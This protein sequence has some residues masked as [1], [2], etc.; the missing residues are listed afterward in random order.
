VRAA[1]VRRKDTPFREKGRAA[2]LGA[3]VLGFGALARS[4]NLSGFVRTSKGALKKGLG[5]AIRAHAPDPSP[6]DASHFGLQR[7]EAGELAISGVSLPS[8]GAQFGSPL[9]VVN[10]ARLRDNARRFVNAARKGPASC[11]VFYSFKT[12]PVPG[13]I[14][15]LKAEGIGAEVIS[16]YELWLAQRLGFPPERIVYNGPVKSEASLREAIA[17]D[18]LMLNV[19]HR[20]ELPLLVRVARELGRRPRVGVRV[21]LPGGWAGQFG[22]P[23]AK[24]MALRVFEEARDSGALSVVGLHVHRGGM[25]RSL[26]DVESFVEQA[27]AFTD[28]LRERL[29]IELSLLNLGGSL[30]SPS[31]RGLGERELRLN[32]TFSS[33]IVAPEPAEALTI[34]Q[35]LAVVSERVAA[36]YGRIGKVAPRVLLEPGRSLTSDAQMLLTRVQ[37]LKADGD[38]EYAILDAGINVADSCRN[39]YHQL[40]VASAVAPGP[41]QVVAIA[42]P[43]CSPGDTLYWGVR[44]PRLGPGDCLAI[45]DAGAYFVPFSTSFSFPRPAIV[46]IDDGV[47]SLLRRAETFEDLLALDSLKRGEAG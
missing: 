14:A 10:A 41:S 20:E 24:G 2:T 30:G 33:E 34:E 46:T 5:A 19:N 26:S 45:M 13:V 35:H 1:A 4:F 9:H 43:I 25:L 27:L 18:I 3:D 23:A 8:L 17:A 12:N 32:R 6:I 16:H 47:T 28:E 7:N 21:T 29:G 38:R 36:H 11:D 39:E 31:V 37:S 40:L 42:G 15:L 22:T 44:L